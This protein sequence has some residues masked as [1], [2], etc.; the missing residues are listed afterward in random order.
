[1]PEVSIVYYLSYIYH[2]HLPFSLVA[3]PATCPANH[4]CSNGGQC[5]PDPAGYQCVCDRGFTG[6]ECESE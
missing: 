1:M 3:R 4:L 6:V 2:F 5:H